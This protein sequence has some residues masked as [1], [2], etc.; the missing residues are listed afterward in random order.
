MT[1]ELE[2]KDLHCVVERGEKW[3]VSF[4]ARVGVKPIVDVMCQRCLR[5]FGHIERRED[6]SWLKKVQILAVDGHSGR[7]RPP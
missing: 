1:T 5:W 3:L 4:N 7:G 6:N 2:E